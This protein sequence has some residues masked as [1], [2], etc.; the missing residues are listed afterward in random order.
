MGT[1]I[2]GKRETSVFCRPITEERSL[3]MK[4][5]FSSSRLTH[6]GAFT[7]HPFL[8]LN[9]LGVPLP[10]HWVY[11]IGAVDDAIAGVVPGFR[12]SFGSSVALLAA[13]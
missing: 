8:A 10:L 5:A 1:R 4:S 11:R 3:P 13:K 2:F 12:Q 9:K 7:R 6:H